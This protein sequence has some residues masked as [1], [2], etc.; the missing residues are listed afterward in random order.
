MRYRK[1]LISRLD[2]FIALLLIAAVLY[3]GYRINVG[4]HYK[5]NWK[6]IPQYLFRYDAEN[7]KW[8]ANLLM[9]GL[10]TTIRLSAWGTV[11]AM[12]IGTVMGLCRISQSLFKRLVSGT[13]VELMRNIPPL[14]LIFIFYFF[15]SEQFLPVLG[16]EEF[17]RNS[18]WPV[19]WVMAVLFAPPTLL[20]EF[21]SATVTLAVFEG[22]YITEIVRAGIQSV[23]K[24]QW[25]AACAMGLSK[26]QQMRYVVLPQAFGRVLPPLT[27]QFIS[28]IK[29]SA[30]VSVISIQELTF[31]GME[32]IS[33]T[34]LTFEIWITVALL[35]L[36]LT[37][38]CS[39]IVGRIETYVNRF[40]S[41]GLHDFVRRG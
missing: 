19:Q 7:E 35:Y 1:Y 28:T 3:I 6:I 37:L 39:M 10:F 24:G 40:L 34:Y 30:I 25:E 32:L 36:M 20:N 16:V 12:F 21:L 17:V 8:V 5:W 14:V 15:V 9:Q 18:S 38:P 31:Q 22:A 4:L 29:D 13:Y 33:A 23:E 41:V 11:L 26:W 2:I 27:G